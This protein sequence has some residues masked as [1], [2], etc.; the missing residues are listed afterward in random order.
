MVANIWSVSQV[1]EVISVK[2]LGGGEMPGAFEVRQQ[3]EVE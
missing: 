2:V 1:E 3:T